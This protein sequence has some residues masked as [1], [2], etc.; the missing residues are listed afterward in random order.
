MCI[1]TK[2]LKPII[3]CIFNSSNDIHKH[4]LP[5]LCPDSFQYTKH[6]VLIMCIVVEC[7]SG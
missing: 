2:Y 7:S 6:D 4:D 3:N 5:L 1:F